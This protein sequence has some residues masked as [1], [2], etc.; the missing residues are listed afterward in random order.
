[1]LIHDNCALPK[2]QAAAGRRAAR[3]IIGRPTRVGGCPHAA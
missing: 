3:A 2:T 1:M